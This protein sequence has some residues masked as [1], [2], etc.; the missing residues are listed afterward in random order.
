MGPEKLRQSPEKGGN[1]HAILPPKAVLVS[2]KL[3]HGKYYQVSAHQPKT[4][5][6][7]AQA[8]EFERS[9]QQDL[10]FAEDVKHPSHRAGF[11]VQGLGKQVSSHFT[12]NR[13]W[14][15]ASMVEHLATGNM[16]S[17]ILA[18]Q[19]VIQQDQTQGRMI[20]LN[21]GLNALRLFGK[22]AP[23]LLCKQALGRVCSAQ[24]L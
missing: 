12:A 16:S 13:C 18:T 3:A 21:A 2:S 8:T 15:A 24:L 11:T 6:P 4:R 20:C 9:P 17:S 14:P 1:F 19:T 5:P 7:G 22:A 23:R 10:H